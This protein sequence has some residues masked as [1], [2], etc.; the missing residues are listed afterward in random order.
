MKKL[1]AAVLTLVLVFILASCGGSSV[2]IDT[3][4]LA[5]DIEAGGLF[6]DSLQPIDAS[7]IKDVVGIDTTNCKSAEY[8]MGAGATGEEYGVFECANETDAKALAQELTDHK[9]SLLE[10]YASYSPDAVPRIENAVIEQSGPYVLFITADKYE[11][12]QT[13]ADNYFA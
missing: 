8:H 1:I 11:A 5:S 7:R 3:S 2:S 12:A 10:T 13:I 9:D 6:A 4:A